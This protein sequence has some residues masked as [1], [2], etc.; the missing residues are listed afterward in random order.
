[1]KNQ[2]LS[3]AR[4][5]DVHQLLST[6]NNCTA[7][8]ISTTAEIS[9]LQLE[10]HQIYTVIH[11]RAPPS[12]GGEKT[13]IDRALL[14][15]NKSRDIS[16]SLYRNLGDLCEKHPAHDLYFNL[17]LSCELR[18]AKY[19]FEFRFAFQRAESEQADLVW[20]RSC[21]SHRGRHSPEDRVRGLHRIK[22]PLCPGQ[23]NKNK[24]FSVRIGEGLLLERMRM[25]EPERSGFQLSSYLNRFLDN[26]SRLRLARLVSETV[27][28]L[29]LTI[30]NHRSLESHNVMVIA[31]SKYE[32]AE[33]LESRIQV[34]LER[35]DHTRDISHPRDHTNAR[36]ILS[37]LGWTL[38]EVGLWSPI[39]RPNAETGKG[40]V[41]GLVEK[42]KEEAGE[43]YSGAVRYCLV[44]C[45]INGSLYEKHISTAFYNRVV[46]V[47]K[48]QEAEDNEAK[49]QAN[50][51]ISEAI[52]PL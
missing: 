26:S 20:M 46:R 12:N 10:F 29:D 21:P 34:R 35:Q 36:A 38:L 4:N 42:V 40:I 30:W 13:E 11:G 9:K 45:P 41:D 51:G 17:D 19:G 25:K 47:L 22:Y 28:R 43:L 37:S 49:R 23:L 33:S 2:M 3:K 39:P 48:D 16:Q 32:G 18:E 50:E 31:P 1:M 24:R 44:D 5:T 7:R 15:L 8:A 27:L 6:L 52:G 14:Y